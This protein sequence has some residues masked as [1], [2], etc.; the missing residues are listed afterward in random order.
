MFQI[1]KK[2][3]RLVHIMMAYLFI[4]SIKTPSKYSTCHVLGRVLMLCS[5]EENLKFNGGRETQG[6]RRERVLSLMAGSKPNTLSELEGAGDETKMR[7]KHIMIKAQ[8]PPWPRGS[9][10]WCI[11]LHPKGGG[12]EPWAGHM[13]GLWVPFL[14]GMHW[15]GN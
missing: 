1:L 8:L 4:S 13:P 9:V 5:I 2:T 12:F 10:A 11:L 7:S 3:K 6:I 15:R 14:V